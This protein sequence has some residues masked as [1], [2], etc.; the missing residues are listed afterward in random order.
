MFREIGDNS[1]NPFIKVIARS[2][3][4]KNILLTSTLILT[5]F[6]PYF[7]Y[8]ACSDILR[9]GLGYFFGLNVKLSMDDF[10]QIQANIL[11]PVQASTLHALY[12]RAP[13]QT[14]PRV[15]KPPQKLTMQGG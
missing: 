5:V 7:V 9:G 3:E 12:N 8:D 10:H 4:E 6:T 15:E 13:V 2:L 1:T 11:A 14:L